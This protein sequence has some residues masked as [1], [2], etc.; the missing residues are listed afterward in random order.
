MNLD[1]DFAHFAPPI[2]VLVF[3]CIHQKIQKESF[4]GTPCNEN[5]AKTKTLGQREGRTNLSRSRFQRKNCD[6]WG[7]CNCIHW[8]SSAKNPAQS[9]IGLA[10]VLPH[11]Q[12]REIETTNGF[13]A[14]KPSTFAPPFSQPCLSCTCIWPLQRSL[15]LHQHRKHPVHPLCATARRVRMSGALP[16]GRALQ[17]LHL[18]LQG[19][20]ALPRSL[21]PPHLLRFKETRRQPVG[22][23]GKRLSQHPAAFL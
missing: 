13:Q 19:G 2:K 4:F 8:C 21:L 12:S 5:A 14:F 7:Q 6:N 22:F 20:V 23:G 3:W 10:Q 15:R 9:L 1:F 18:Q 16:G 17:V 11:K